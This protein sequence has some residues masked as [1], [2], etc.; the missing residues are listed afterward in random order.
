M[1]K[2]KERIIFSQEDVDALMQSFDD[3]SGQ[4]GIGESE[5]SIDSHAN[6]K[7]KKA[8]EQITFSQEDVDALKQSFDD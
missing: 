7:M 4:P 6:Q 3:D 2:A 5:V 1:K 8:K